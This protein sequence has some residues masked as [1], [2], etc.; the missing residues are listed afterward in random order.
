MIKNY[1]KIA[2]R[3]MLK[4]KLFSA[5]NVFGLSV[6]MTCCMLLLL[7]IL[8]ETSFD[9]H[10]EHV[11][12]LYLVRSENVRF[13]GEKMDNP[14]APSPYAQALKQEFPEVVQVT[15]AWMNFLENKTLLKVE[16]SGK[17]VKSIFE[18]KGCHVDSTFFDM[19][20]YHFVEGDPKTALNDPHSVVLS[21]DVASKLFG[22]VSPIDKVINIGGTDGNA[23][24]F[25]GDRRLSGRKCPL[26]FRCPF[27]SPHEIGLGRKLFTTAQSGLYE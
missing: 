1:L 10:Q 15:R 2:W 5:I 18:T 17:T 20:S 24:N 19:F 14:R 9:K 25:Q 12:E 11:N 26:T 3:N 27:L 22:N 13:S 21:E 8:S 4:S 16:N 7:Y 23:E 6:G